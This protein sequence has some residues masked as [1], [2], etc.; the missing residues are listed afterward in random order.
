M[1]SECV[2]VGLFVSRAAAAVPESLAYYFHSAWQLKWNVY[3]AL[4]LGSGC[5]HGLTWSALSKSPDAN[6]FTP[7]P[8]PPC[9]LADS[10]LI[11]SSLSLVS[12][13]CATCGLVDQWTNGLGFVLLLYD[14]GGHRRCTILST[15]F[16][17]LSSLSVKQHKVIDGWM[18]K[19]LM[20]A[21]T[22]RLCSSSKQPTIRFG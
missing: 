3:L 5:W 22:M 21:Q 1:R 4:L 15:Q 18:H 11:H 7:G 12:F 9:R 16:T 14:D 13:A 17:V 19:L 20:A 6:Q 2:R 10:L 8:P